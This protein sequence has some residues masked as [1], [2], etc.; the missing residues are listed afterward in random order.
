[1]APSAPPG[2]D[3]PLH[4]EA[5]VVL[6]DGGTAHLR[7]IRPD[8]ADALQTFHLGQSRRSTYFRF[9]APLERLPEHEL[10][11]FTQV[12]H[13]DR[14]A[15]VVVA[16]VA[17]A[18]AIIGVGRY[19]RTGPGTAEVAFN[20]ADR[21]HGRGLGSVL[22]EHLAAAARERGIRRFTAE[23][24]PQNARMLA[25]FRDAG[26]EVEQHLDDGIVW[27]AV[28]LDPTERSRVVM[29]DR[30]HRAEARSVRGML[31]PRSV[32][33]VTDGRDPS[34][35]VVVRNL[36]ASGGGQ[37]R[38]HPAVHVVG[39]D[40]APQP[41]RTWQTLD[42]VVG[43]VDLLVLAVPA[44]EAAETVRRCA[45]LHARA[46]VV[47]TAGFAETGP[48]GVAHQREL[49]RTAHASGMRVL[50]PASFGFLRTAAEPVDASLADAPLRPGRLG[51]FCQSAPLAVGLLASARRRGVGVSTFVSSGNRADVSGNDL[52]QFWT[53][54][55]ETDVVALYVESIGNPRKFARVARRL[56]GVK[57][58]VVLTAGTSG[59]VL[60][61][62]HVL[63]T[64]HVPRR[65]LE[66]MMA[67]AG[68]LR[69]TSQHQL[70]DVAQLL[71][72]QPLPQGPRVA[73]LASSEPLAALVAEAAGAHGL[74]VSSTR[75]IL[76]AGAVDVG[77]LRAALAEAYA[78]ADAVMV[79]HV[80][81]LGDPDPAVARTVAQAAA[82]SG[83]TTVA[84]L[85]G[86]SGI[87]A[88]LTAP[89]ADGV[90]RTVPAYAA[91]EDGMVALAAAVRH[92]VW[93]ATD[94]G[95]P[96]SPDGLDRARARAMVAGLLTQSEDVVLLEPARAADLLACYGLSVWPTRV[97]RDEEEA[98]A[99]AE[100][101]GWPVAVKSAV[102]VLR[103]RIDLGG[104]RL[105][106]GN[107]TAL[108]EAMA[109]MRRH[110]EPF[111]DGTALFELQHMAPAGAACVI[112]S[113]EDPRFGPVVSFGLAGDAVEL[114]DDV[115]HG[116]APLTPVDVA[117]MIRDVRAAPRLFGH[118]GLPPL[119]V[120]ALE[121]VLARV[122]A[123]A[124]DLPELRRLELHPVV[125]GERGAAVLGAHVELAES[126]RAD[127]GR[128]ALPD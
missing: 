54:D 46:V 97:V 29:A 98:T 36:L 61:P 112:R 123:M 39:W 20:V 53:E 22:L 72:H 125:V 16:D 102:P 79:V 100:E 51:L 85:R 86:L 45:R 108:A 8:D 12:D 5:D 49:V 107:P 88:E 31:T 33:V 62:G 58:V 78:D 63:R 77:A 124:D 95:G 60:P 40:E 35:Q 48:D 103:H 122:A 9:F 41:A 117:E 81:L 65:A 110:L 75:A 64:T 69:V 109:Q 14:V 80:P 50:G 6:R 119:D 38:R 105:D 10:A 94:R 28:D 66:E 24:L 34:A 104:V 30:E 73:V 89:D 25:V 52:M 91:P 111:G 67:R 106:V 13:R 96:V 115:S 83:S 1:M 71:L 113:A 57:P 84:C 74:T 42:A 15:L 90:D 47:L 116:V 68:V 4:W 7:P 92:G 26:Y 56:A 118:R 70:L 126:G 121:D 17:G 99:A 27:V 55:P 23:V 19:D 114:L 18:E 127:T 87:T 21:H 76:G 120:A 43:P 11:H 2:T 59:H 37:G 3:Y 93:R 32:L 82:A 101:L 128:R 44:A